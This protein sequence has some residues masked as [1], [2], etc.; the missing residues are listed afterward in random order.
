MRTKGPELETVIRGLHASRI[1]VG[2]HTFSGGI[3]VWISNEL[4]RVREDCVFD[5]ANPITD[6]NSVGSWLHSTALH[7]FPDSDY[8]RG[9]QPHDGA[10]RPATERDTGL[11]ST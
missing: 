10:D 11:P 2:F 7:L 3:A 6:E 9:R 1:R 4:Y 5:H 8:A